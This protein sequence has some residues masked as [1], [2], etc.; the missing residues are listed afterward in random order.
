M[1]TY[2]GYISMMGHGLGKTPDARHSLYETLN[3][4][5]RAFWT[6]GMRQPF[7]HEWSWAQRVNRTIEV[8]ALVDQVVLPRDFGSPIALRLSTTSNGSVIQVDSDKM[9][10]YRSLQSTP[11][12]SLFLCFDSP[13]VQFKGTGPTRETLQVYPQQSAARTDLRVTYRSKWPE[14]DASDADATPPIDPDFE[15][16][17]MM[18]ARGF[19]IETENRTQMFEAGPIASELERLV[20]VDLDKQPKIRQPDA[21]ALRSSRSRGPSME[22]ETISRT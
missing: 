2:G 12:L 8:P 9:Q 7:M 6:C 11:S 3:Q 17:F 1:L 13:P 21:S 20:L 19:A 15:R 18:I 16:L 4:A 14:I 5:G 10:E 22:F